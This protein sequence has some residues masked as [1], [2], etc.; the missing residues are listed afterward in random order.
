MLQWL[1]ESKKDTMTMVGHPG[2]P[3]RRRTHTLTVQLGESPPVNL[4]KTT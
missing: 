3:G 1:P 4:I 2:C